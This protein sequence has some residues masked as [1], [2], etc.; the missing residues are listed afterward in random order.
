MTAT[1]VLGID[2]G[3]TNSVLAYARLEEEPS[4]VELL[5]I[6]Q[7]TAASTVEHRLLLPSF[8]YIAPEH[9]AAS[10][11]LDL[12]WEGRRRFAAGEYARRQGA[13]MP[14]RTVAAAKSWLCYS[15]VDRR[16]AILPYGA[17]AE[18][19]KISP[20]AASQRYLEHLV[21][22]WNARFP[23]AP[24]G[25]Q[26]VVLTVPASFDAAARELTREA[27]IA[28]GLPV[29]LVLLEEP[30]AAV[31][32][33]LAARG[34]A[35]RRDL[36][37]GHRLLVCDVGG[38]T[39][40]LTLI[41][42]AEDHGE[43][44]LR[45]L[46]VGDHLLVGGDNMDLALA[47]RTA[48]LFAAQGVK[49][50]AWQSVALWHACRDAKEALLSGDAP[51][52]HRVSVL[53]RGS[54]VIGGTVSVD[55]P[56]ELAV[57]LLVSGFFPDCA[58][59][60]RPQRRRQSGF[61]EI[62]L[63]FEADPA[64]TRHLAA[65]LSAHRDDG[66]GA[67]AP[68]HVLF[69][70]GVFKTDLLRVGLLTTLGRWAPGGAAPQELPGQR[71]LDFAVARGAAYYGWTKQHGGMRIRGG[72]A[73]SY[74]VGVETAGLAIPGAPR[75]LRAL[76]VVPFGME[77]GTAV[78][79]PSGE[80][81][82]V[83]GEPANFRFFSSAVRP[84]DKPGD[85]LPEIDDDELAET[86]SLETMLEAGGAEAETY[87]PVKFQSRITELGVFELWCV[88]TASQQRWKLQFSIRHDAQDGTEA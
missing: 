10:G 57:E 25:R 65:F 71:D 11:A 56:R 38:G 75:P 51:P 72:T 18:V 50:N 82:L 30:Q 87:V 9:E 32:S 73:R 33:W 86:D 49:L 68:S 74:Y 28:A 19:D 76:C 36:K 41:D 31:Y 12:P 8:L 66:G 63:P 79:V 15:R 35:W 42:V 53:G 77:E 24:A 40:D 23:D 78:D 3:T 60:D 2:L 14:Q 37:A 46:A 84:G 39:T 43:L 52:M 80:I 69:N 44:E 55:V 61:Q 26:L 85:V 27:A 4:Q 22:A 21:A 58:L 29:D 70:G 45:R 88:S 34:D 81:G 17:P 47:H 59:S 62:G 7:L 54:K 67:V 13:E 20:L 16:Q 64:I 83:L 6:P 48:E 1:Y 5:E